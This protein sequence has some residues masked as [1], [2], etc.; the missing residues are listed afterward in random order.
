MAK[1]YRF[2]SDGTISF[3]DDRAVTFPWGYNGGQHGMSSEKL[4]IHADGTEERLPSKVETFPSRRATGSSSPPRAR[5]ARAIRSTREPERTAADVHAG[6]VSVEAAASEYG[7]IVSG[8]GEIDDAATE[9]QREQMRVRAPRA[10]RVRLRAAA[11]DGAAGQ[12]QIAEERRSFDARLA[13]RSAS[14]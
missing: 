10:A 13:G 7:V 4:I 12:E 3:Q 14:A 6:L 11:L 1:T 9:S 8:D 5:A 2:L